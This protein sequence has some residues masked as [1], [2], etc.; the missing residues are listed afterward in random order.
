MQ[1]YITATFKNEINFCNDDRTEREKET[2]S[3]NP[4]TMKSTL[5]LDFLLY[6][7][8]IFPYFSN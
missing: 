3:L 2:G 7:K 8:T 1:M 4:L 6:D 5:P